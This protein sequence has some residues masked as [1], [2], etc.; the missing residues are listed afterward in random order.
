MIRFALLAAP[1]LLAGC[2]RS[3]EPAQPEAGAD[4][5]ASRIGT[6]PS[7][8]A[9]PPTSSAVELAANIPSRAVKGVPPQ[10]ANVFAI[11]KLGDIGG[12]N[13]GPRAGGC[14]F[15]SGGTEMLIAAGP[16]DPAISG[17]GV[18]RIGGRLLELDTPP[19]GIA[20]IRT[21]TDFNGEGFSIRLTPT[22]PGKG[23]ITIT[24]SQGQ[25]KTVAGDWT[26]A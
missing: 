19:G 25:Q 4:D 11:E 9:A 24:N 14:T 26:C 18:V 13:L 15:S 21:G 6:A 23:T 3:P 22:A 2:S 1:L 8:G 12:V 7:A 17:K 16:A 5:F 10:G 20:A